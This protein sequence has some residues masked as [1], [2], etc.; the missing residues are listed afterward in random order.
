AAVAEMG[1]GFMIDLARNV[2]NSVVAYR[3][4]RA[5][6]ARPG[7][8][9]RG[10]TVGIIGYGVIAQYLAPLALAL[11]M[12][13]IVSDPYKTVTD[14]GIRQVGFEALL[15]EADFVVCLA[16]ATGETENLIDA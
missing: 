1:I 4:G 8:E 16:V 2:S 14:A 12:R 7:R 15:A 3:E 13:V 6:V 5:P 10:A 9:L 11:G